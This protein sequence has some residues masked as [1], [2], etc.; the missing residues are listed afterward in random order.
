[1]ICKY[2][3]ENDPV[4]R[5]E[6]PMIA[7]NMYVLLKEDQALLIDPHVSEAAAQLLKDHHVAKLLIILTHEHYDHISGVNYFRAGWNC[8]VIGNRLCKAYAKEPAK[9][10]AAHFMA[11][12]IT[13]SETERERIRELTE[14]DY[15][16]E[17]DVDF[18]QELCFA[19]DSFRLCLHETPGHSPGSICV[20]IN[21]HYLFTGDSLIPGEKTITRLPGGNRALYQKLTV[22]YLKGFEKDTVIFP[23]H[24]VEGLLRDML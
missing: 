1:M 12:F 17:V 15:C 8:K 11:M 23:G 20:S 14:Q 4:Y 22:P 21:D 10:L 16:C 7:S 19:F 9:N 24:G 3:I 13:R 2:Q 6:M 18:E 5:F